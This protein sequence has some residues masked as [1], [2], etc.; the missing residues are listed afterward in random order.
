MD[1]LRQVK[2]GLNSGLRVLGYQMTKFE[3]APPEATSQSVA[4]PSDFSAEESALWE[5]VSPHT[6]VSP[7]RIATLSQAIE[8]IIK[9]NIPGDM[10]ECGCWKGGSSLAMLLTLLRLGVTDRDVYVYDAFEEGW[11]KALEVDV[12]ADGRSAHQ[13]YL[14]AMAE[15]LTLED[16]HASHK[17]VKDLLLSAGYPVERIHITQGFVEATIPATI[18]K[19]IALLRLDTDWY[20]STKHELEHLYPRLSKRGVLIMDDYGCWQGA[21]KATDEYVEENGL[22]MFLQRVDSGGCR[23]GIKQD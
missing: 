3:A 2:V 9:K 8:Y 17:K 20:E 22:C 7:E 13:M 18:P 11:P 12:A 15:G 1:L 16:I 4:A 5:R 19:S 14:D 6:M 23:M 21:Q 10:V